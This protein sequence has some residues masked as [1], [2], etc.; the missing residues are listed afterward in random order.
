V[1]APLADLHTH[2][3]GAIRFPVLLAHLLRNPRLDWS[4]YRRSFLH[5]FGHDPDPAALLQRIRHGDR[6]ACAELRRLFLFTAG[7]GPGFGRFQAKFDLL[8]AASALRQLPS[9]RAAPVALARELHIFIREILR[10]HARQGVAHAE[11]RMVLPAGPAAHLAAPVLR[12]LVANLARGAALGVDARLAVSLPRESPWEAWD[13]VRHAL[14]E[15]AAP[16]L[17]AID[18]CAVE[19]GHP[20]RAQAEFFRALRDHNQTHP[21]RAL[22]FLYHVGESFTDKSL[23]SAIRWVQEAAEMGAHRLGHALALGLDPL[24]LGPHQRHETVAE[25][26]DQL[27]YDLHHA[28]A[29][30]RHGVRIDL[31]AAEVELI[32]LRHADP[33]ATLTH[34]Y[35]TERLQQLRKRQDFALSVVRRSGAVI[36]VCPASNQRIAGWSDPRDHPVCRFLAARIP[37]VI[38][39]DDPGLLQTTL[40]R[41]LTWFQRVAGL[42]R[43]DLH[44]H[45]AASW[46]CRSELLSGRVLL[47]S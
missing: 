5:A 4:E 22:A 40:R 6:R 25:R 20:P 35:D 46:N 31:A 16:Q 3:Y 8:I 36:E 41:E 42:S 21:E 29:L 1:T 32:R 9:V 18:F 34:R 24:R 33:A 47:D 11:F 7:D 27:C 37:V 28:A 26:I 10:D 45:L 19:E 2:L 17:T 13:V 39:T 23:E 12:L 44:D 15:G 38:A 30:D 43:A 14:R